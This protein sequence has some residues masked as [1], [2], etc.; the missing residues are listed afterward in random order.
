VQ[1]LMGRHEDKA[2]KDAET[3]EMSLEFARRITGI[4]EARKAKREAG[5]AG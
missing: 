2:K 1:P 5:A 4:I 3:N